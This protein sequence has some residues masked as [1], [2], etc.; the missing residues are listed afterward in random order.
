MH[1]R[2]RS[3]TD[4]HVAYLY[5]RLEVGIIRDVLQD[6][7]RVRA[8]AGLERLDRVTEDVAHADVGWRSVRRSAGETLVDRVVLAVRAHAVLHQWHVLVLIVRM[9]ETRAWLVRIKHT[10]FYHG[11]AP[12]FGSYGR[13]F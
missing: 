9:V 13:R 12:H 10:D 4:Y 5:H 6:L 2:S 7:V 8:E 11:P 1:C 3:V